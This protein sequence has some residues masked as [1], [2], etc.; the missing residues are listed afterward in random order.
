MS[1]VICRWIY[2]EE[3]VDIMPT[4][5]KILG[6]SNKWYKDGFKNRSMIELAD[7][8][9]I[10]ILPLSYY[11]ATKIEAVR[12]RGGTDW[13]QSHDFEDIIYLFNNCENILELITKEK[14][15][16]L[17]DFISHWAGECLQRNNIREEIE[18]SLPYGDEGRVDYILEN[19]QRLQD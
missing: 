17:K 4:D 13:R 16:E 19:L 1:G 18:C 14:N 10:N 6:F 2:Q 7:N 5:A 9:K 8:V 11:L 3:I 15:R 12:G